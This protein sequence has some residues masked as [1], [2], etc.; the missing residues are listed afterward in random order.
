MSLR[1]GTIAEA[2]FLTVRETA[3]QERLAVTSNGDVE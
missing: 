2:I 1:G 3:S